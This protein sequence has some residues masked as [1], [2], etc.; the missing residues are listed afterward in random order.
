MNLANAHHLGNVFYHLI[1]ISLLLKMGLRAAD[2]IGDVIHACGIVLL[3]RGVAL[4][5]AVLW[6]ALLLALRLALRMALRLLAIRRH[7]LLA[8]DITVRWVH[9]VLAR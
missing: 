8:V 1:L 9:G 3:D 7:H 5:Q 4:G 2:G 6:R